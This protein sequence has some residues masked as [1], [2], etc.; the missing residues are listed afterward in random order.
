MGRADRPRPARLLNLLRTPLCPL[1]LCGCFFHHRATEDTEG[2][3]SPVTAP[4]KAIDEEAQRAEGV[5]PGL[6]RLA[7]GCED[8]DDLRADLAQ[9]LHAVEVAAEVVLQ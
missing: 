9:A 3:Q 5:T 7:V 1:C 6:V 4:H 2:T 8:L